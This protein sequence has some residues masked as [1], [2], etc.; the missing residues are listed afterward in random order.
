MS[1]HYSVRPSAVPTSAVLVTELGTGVL[2]LQDCQ[3]GVTAYVSPENAATLRAALDAAF[4]G[5]GREIDI[6]PIVKPRV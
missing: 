4:N 3:T 6:P 5:A 2:L 1:R